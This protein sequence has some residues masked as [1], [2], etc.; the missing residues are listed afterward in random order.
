MTLSEALARARQL[1]AARQ[2]PSAAEVLHAA[3]AQWPDSDE[4]WLL[5]GLVEQ[6]RGRIAAALDALRRA[7]ALAPQRLD[8]S[9]MLAE[10]EL[11]ESN[12][13]NALR[14]FDRIAASGEDAPWLWQRRARCLRGQQRHDEAIALLTQALARHPGEDELWLQRGLV[15][16]DAGHA[17]VADADY[18]E[19]LR[20]APQRAD[21]LAACIALD[22]DGKDMALRAAAE[23]IAAANHVDGEARAHLHLVLGKQ[24]A[25]R[26]EDAAALAHWHAGNALRRARVG[27]QDPERLR[28]LVEDAIAAHPA[29]AMGGG[30]DDPRPLLIVGMPRSGTTLAEQILAAHPLV[31]GAGELEV[32]MRE[33]DDLYVAHGARWPGAERLPEADVSRI[34]SR[35]L[36]ALADGAAPDAL[37]LVDKQPANFFQLGLLARVLPNARVVWCR[38]DPRDVALSIYAEHFA[39]H[40][41]YATRFEEIAALIEAQERIM[42]HWERTLPLPIHELRYETLVQSP[43]AEIRRLVAFAGLEWEPECLDFHRSVKGVRTPSRWQV[44]QPINARSVGRWRRWAEAFPTALHTLAARYESEAGSA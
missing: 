16:E 6:Q 39:P 32:L 41:L 25:A 34:A 44:R 3:T 9:R 29:A 27:G 36:A 18:R 8:V 17:D 31:H 26:G 42:R 23:A 1:A 10:M 4:A 28:A 24:A 30:V 21:A 11:E 22:R 40:A 2:W 33:A 19:A 14:L 20:L 35:Y 12:F 5:R 7:Q 13:A 37:R 38:R 43:E 15:H